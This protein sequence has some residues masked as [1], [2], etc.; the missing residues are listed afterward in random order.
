MS[1]LIAE[2]DVTGNELGITN[3]DTS[4]NPDDHTDFG[5]VDVAGVVETRTFKIINNGTAVLDLGASAVTI[6]GP[7]GTDFTV[8]TQ[9][10]VSVAVGSEETFQI[11][12][13]PSELD[14]RS[15]TISINNNDPDESPFTF[16]IAGTGVEFLD[17]GDGPDAEPGAL[18]VGI[19]EVGSDFQIS[20]SPGSTSIDAVD[21]WI[22][23]NSD[24]NQYLV[25]WEGE[26]ANSASEI[27]GQ[28]ISSDGMELVDDFQISTTGPPNDRNWDANDPS[29]A[30]KPVHRRVSRGLGGRPPPADHRHDQL[31]R[32]RDIRPTHQRYR[33][34]RGRRDP[35]EHDR[36]REPLRLSDGRS[37][38]RLWI[39]A[40]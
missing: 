2:I 28:V 29:V 8:S 38:G 10:P 26:E 30:Y 20:E 17:Y 18:G 9:P 3:G 11:E 34:P 32:R 36:P 19:A 35:G 7:H 4:P 27:Y 25:V 39:G 14:T 40:R 23:Y 22:A 15:A 21:P 16:A 37:K 24:L 5:Q 1:I 31:H 13:N 33:S 12:F 6:S